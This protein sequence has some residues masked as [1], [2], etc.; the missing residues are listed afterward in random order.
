MGRLTFSI[1]ELMN[2]QLST[3]DK[4]PR[5]T[6]RSNCCAPSAWLD[7]PQVSVTPNSYLLFVSDFFYRPD[8]FGTTGRDSAGLFQ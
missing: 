3:N 6:L 4:E 5:W 1:N 8:N 2:I 7:L